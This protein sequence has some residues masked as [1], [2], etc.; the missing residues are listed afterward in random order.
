MRPIRLPSEPGGVVGKAASMGGHRVRF[1]KILFAR[2]QV[3]RQVITVPRR[4]MVM[5]DGRTGMGHRVTDQA[6]AAGRRAGGCYLAICGMPVLPASLTA[7]ARVHCPRCEQE[8]AP[9]RNG[10]SAG[11]N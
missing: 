2:R 6:F 7:P 3:R 11:E 1:R 5:T 8:S 10:N 4:I 9:V